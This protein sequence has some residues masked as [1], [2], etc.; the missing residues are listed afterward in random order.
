MKVLPR[1]V[2]PMKSRL[3]APGAKERAQSWQA[4]F[5]ASMYSRGLAPSSASR[6]AL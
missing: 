4:S 2:P 5:T 6:S 3:G 1:P